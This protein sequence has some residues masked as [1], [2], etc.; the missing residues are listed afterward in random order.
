M[1]HAE[2]EEYHIRLTAGCW[3][4]NRK[5]CVLTH[6]GDPVTAAIH[7]DRDPYAEE[8]SYWPPRLQKAMPASEILRLAERSK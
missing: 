4:C 8:R 3:Y 2:A 7:P 5:R 1:T 6:K